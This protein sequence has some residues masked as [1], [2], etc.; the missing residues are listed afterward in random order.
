MSGGGREGVALKKAQ[1]N[2]LNIYTNI[3]MIVYINIHVCVYRHTY[4]RSYM[5]VCVCVCVCVFICSKKMSGIVHR[6]CNAMC[7]H[8][9]REFM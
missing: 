7:E 5:C 8:T 3:Y 1:F 6:Y 2:I 4:I 9:V